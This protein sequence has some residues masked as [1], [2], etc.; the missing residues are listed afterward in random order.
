MAKK[1]QA[2]LSKTEKSPNQK[3]SK[4]GFDWI[5]VVLG[6]L[7][8][9][10]LLVVSLDMINGKFAEKQDELIEEKESDWGWIVITA[11]YTVPLVLTCAVPVA[12]CI[13]SKRDAQRKHLIKALIIAGSILIV[14][15]IVCPV[16]ISGLLLEKEFCEMMEQKADEEEDFIYPEELPSVE[17]VTL[18]LQ[19]AVEWTAKAGLGL[20]IVGAYQGLRYKKLR[21]GEP[22]EEIIPEEQTDDLPDV[23]WVQR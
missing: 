16:Q 9:S 3:K 10:V 23:D 17:E 13:F 14:I 12:M 8:L 21:D 22:D 5:R 15:C 20:V 19:R 4:I 2:S 18:K 1:N 6:I 11:G 7:I